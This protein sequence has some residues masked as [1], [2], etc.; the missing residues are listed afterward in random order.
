MGMRRHSCGRTVLTVICGAMLLAS[1]CTMADALELSKPKGII[2]GSLGLPSR[3]DAF[4]DAAT[5]GFGGGIGLGIFLVPHAMLQLSA[6]YTTFGADE[7]GLRK[8]YGQAADVGVVG[9]EISVLY[10]AASLRLS[11]V[12][13]PAIHAYVVG[14]AGF[15]R[16]VP[17]KVQFDNVIV[18]RKTENTAGFHAGVGL[19]VPL[20]S[21]IDIFADAAYVMGATEGDRTA[22]IPLR[23]GLLFELTAE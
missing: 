14:G 5:L 2:Y 4:D 6:E 13:L 19:D 11:V 12:R 9:G 7:N 17:D 21:L 8:V 20:G 15:F 1:T 22:Y 10:T 23:V 18:E 3:P 16:Y